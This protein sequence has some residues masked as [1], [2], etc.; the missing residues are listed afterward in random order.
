VPFV[1]GQMTGQ[2]LSAVI[3]TECGHCGRPLRLQ[4]DSDL[5]MRVLDGPQQPM[6]SIPQLDI[7]A[8]E[9]SIIDGF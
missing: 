9:P 2:V 1:Q 3:Q 6:V 7:Q 4:V 8:L 5:A